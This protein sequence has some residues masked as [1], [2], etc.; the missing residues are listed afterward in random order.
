MAMMSPS[1]TVLSAG[2]EGSPPN[3]W[4]EWADWLTSGPGLGLVDNDLSPGQFLHFL[5]SH[6]VVDM[7]VRV[8]DILNGVTP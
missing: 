8:N 4:K 6:D 2:G 1:R 7:A 3:I 5:V